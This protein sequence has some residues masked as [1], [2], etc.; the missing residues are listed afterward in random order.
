MHKLNMYKFSWLILVVML[1]GCSV[2]MALSGKN[3]PDLS[4]IRVGATRGEIEL[5]LGPPIE[6][7]VAD[8]YKNEI[9]AYE[10]GNQPSGSRAFAHGALS[11]LT[12]G[13]WEVVGTP[14]EAVRGDRKYLSITYDESDIVT[15]LKSIVA[16]GSEQME[17]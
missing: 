9:Y 2:G 8:G 16:P 7:Q 12:L 6:I 17:E 3:D 11:F 15:G 10:L 14:L 1:S 4:V 13:L 5:Q